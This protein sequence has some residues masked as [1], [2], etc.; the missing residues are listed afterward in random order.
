[1]AKTDSSSDIAQT[2]IYLNEEDRRICKELQ[3]QTGLPR[4]AVFR[5]A[6]HRMYFGEEG[7]RRKRLLAISEEIKALI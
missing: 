7:D 2:S 4:S 5:L 1:M 3:E 6:L